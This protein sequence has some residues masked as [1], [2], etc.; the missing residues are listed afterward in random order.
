[1][2]KSKNIQERFFGTPGQLRGS[3]ERQNQ[4]DPPEYHQNDW[5]SGSSEQEVTTP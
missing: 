2:A 1:M 5:E 4:E 3:K